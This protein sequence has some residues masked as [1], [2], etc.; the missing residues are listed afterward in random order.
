MKRLAALFALFAA[1]AFAQ[2]G[3][4]PAES[5][6][7]SRPDGS[8]APA[9]AAP[10][11]EQPRITTGTSYY[12]AETLNELYREL[13]E[14]EKQ[15]RRQR[16]RELPPHMAAQAGE[17]SEI[18]ELRP[19]QVESDRLRDQDELLEKLDPKPR[20]RLA[21]IAEFDKQAAYDI[22]VAERNRQEFMA[23]AYDPGV[24]DGAGRPVT[25]SVGQLASAL[26]A[27]VKAAET[28]IRG[29]QNGDDERRGR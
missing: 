3:A 28:A 12:D 13:Q 23:G 7:E 25:Y 29:D 20:K 18:V 15:R 26:Q 24:P 1:A 10:E 22:Q 16:E 11:R 4:E 27:A 17:D 14:K 21:R 19:Y 6:P 2:E 8:N 5:A 9:Q